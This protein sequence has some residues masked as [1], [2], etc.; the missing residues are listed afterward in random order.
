MSIT[1]L[2]TA[3]VATASFAAP[4]AAQEIDV[5]ATIAALAQPEHSKVDFTEVRFSALLEEPLVISGVLGYGGPQALD[6]QVLVPYREDTQ[7]RADSVTVSREGEKERR[8]ALRRAPELQ[9]L[10]HA[11]SALLG[12]DHAALDRDFTIA[13]SGTAQTWQLELT[14]RDARL[15][16]RIAQFRIDGHDTQAQCFWLFSDA[17]SYSVMLLGPLAHTALPMPPTREWLQAQCV[18]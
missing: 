10:L 14:A 8:F 13:A 3:L 18:S 17:A 9:G 7:I 4:A 12:G 16:Q 1:R 6:R 11:F 2:L 5:A 15:R